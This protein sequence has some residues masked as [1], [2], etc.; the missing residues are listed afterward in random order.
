MEIIKTENLKKYYKKVKALD[1]VSL[2]VNGGEVFS[3]LGENGAGKTTLIKVLCGLIGVTEGEAY[4]DGL[5]INS[6][7]KKI[8]S[9]VGICPQETAVSENSTVKENLLLICSL[10]NENKNKVNEFIK[11]F[12]LTGHENKLAKRLSGGLK[13]RLSIAMSL[14]S[15]PKVLFLDEPTLGLD[16]RAR[17]ELWKLIES[18]KG[19]L[20]VILTT[21]YLEEA[22]ALSDRV[23]IIEKGK[24]LTVGTPKEIIEKTSTAN[25]EEAFIKLTEKENA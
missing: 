13:R 1:G 15:N 2:S 19:K 24:I 4:I 9:I 18:L 3:V 11:S 12:G 21:H 25:L 7:M 10:Y 22:E 16:V 6:E 14:I 20:T 17:R 23:A 5:S 8:K